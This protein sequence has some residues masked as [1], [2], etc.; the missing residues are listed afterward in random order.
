[1]TIYFGL[2]VL[3]SIVSVVVAYLIWPKRSAPGAKALILLM[4][5]VSEWSL[6]YAME[7]IA[8][9]VD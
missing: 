6:G 9:T 5:A 1:M 8:P 2:P 7:L 4:L 3:T